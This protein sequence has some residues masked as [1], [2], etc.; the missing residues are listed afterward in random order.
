MATVKEA[1]AFCRR[2]EGA[3]PALRGLL[4]CPHGEVVTDVIALLTYCR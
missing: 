2:L 4:A 1:I 3:M